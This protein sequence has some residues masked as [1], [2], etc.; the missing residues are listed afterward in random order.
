MVLRRP[1]AVARVL[2]RVTATVREREMFHRGELVLL[3]VSGGPDSVC[4]VESLVRLRRLL[5]VRL[6]VFHFDH[7]LRAGSGADSSYVRRL[8][9]RHHLRF[10]LRVAG[11]SPRGGESV[12]AWA[13]A[14]RT[15][16]A[17]E[18]R[19]EIG[20]PVMAEGHTLD[21]QAET[22]LLNL[23]RGT[24]LD[25]LAGIW[26]GSGERPGSALAQPLL[27]VT[28]AEVDA[29][30]RSLGLR[31]RRDPMNDDPR[32]LR[33]ALRN[34][35]IPALE[36]VTGREIRATIARTAAVLH[37]DRLELMRQALEREASIVERDGDQVRFRAAD[38]V[39]LPASL[40]ARIVRIGLW[41]LAAVDDIG[42]PWTRDSVDAVLDL[43]AGR[44]G[45]RRD[46]PGAR[47]ARRDRV[48][49]HVSSPAA[50]S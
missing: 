42:A 11:D 3:C 9:A 14:R 1:P 13:T 20:S 16:A 37:H 17:N 5:G 19:R 2:E 29:L 25:G 30:C 8:A 27:D 46:L 24:G 26:P 50:T 15:D 4:M 44:P 7:R 40:A 32:Y 6:E 47:T 39:E 23:L 48:Y 49:V 36:R 33:A 22:V 43:A 10:H 31:P 21:D 45:R 34:E 38:L 35:A 28:R 12:E 41:N 18:V